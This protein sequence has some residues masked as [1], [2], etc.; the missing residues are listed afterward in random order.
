MNNIN[1]MKYNKNIP[2][3]CI[4]LKKIRSLVLFTNL[5]YIPPQKT[6]MFMI[7]NVCTTGYQKVRRLMR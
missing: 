2:S 7:L 6:Y 5:K 3:L 1:M 4:F